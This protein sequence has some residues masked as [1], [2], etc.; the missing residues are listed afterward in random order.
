MITFSQPSTKLPWASETTTPGARGQPDL[1]FS[2]RKSVLNRILP[3]THGAHHTRIASKP[4]W[5]PVPRKDSALKVSSSTAP[6]YPSIEEHQHQS[7]G[8]STLQELIHLRYPQ[9][10]TQIRCLHHNGLTTAAVHD[11]LRSHSAKNET[12]QKLLTTAHPTRRHHSEKASRKKPI[13]KI[14]YER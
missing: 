9:C 7:G 3:Q 10:S 12:S 14:D 11:I 2:N 1:R 6:K 5:Q 4:P 13:G 8:A